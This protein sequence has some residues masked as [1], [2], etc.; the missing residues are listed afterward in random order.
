MQKDVVCVSMKGGGGDWSA[1][2]KVYLYFRAP[3]YKYT[4]TICI[5]PSHA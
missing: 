4:N 1:A 2:S 5:H 3:N